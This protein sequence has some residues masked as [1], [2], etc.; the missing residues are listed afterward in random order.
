M[1]FFE[2]IRGKKLAPGTKKSYERRQNQLIRWLEDN[3]SVLCW[4]EQGAF[5]LECVTAEMLCEFLGESSV[6]ED[7]QANR[8][9]KSL[10]TAEGHHSA[11]VNLYR[12]RKI[13]LPE[14]FERVCFIHLSLSKQ[15]T[16]C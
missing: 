2:E 5:H 12:D 7:G 4:D 3:Y 10:S 9:M 6:E 15:I 11:I 14:G 13:E 1:E 8:R 16:I